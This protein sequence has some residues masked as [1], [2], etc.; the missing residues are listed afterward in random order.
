MK[1]IILILGIIS[2]CSA[3]FC[4]Q[5]EGEYIGN[6]LSEQITLARN[7]NFIQALRAIEV[8]SQLYDNRKILSTSSFNQQI[9]IPVNQLHWKDALQLIVGYHNLVL[10][11]QP[12]MYL[13]RDV[14]IVKEK[15]AEE[16]KLVITPNSQQVRISAIFFKADRSLSKEVGINWLTLIDGNIHVN[17]MLDKGNPLEFES[18]R[19]IVSALFEKVIQMGGSITGE[20]GIGITKAPYLDMEIPRPGLDLMSR[21]KGAFDPQGIL[22]PGKIFS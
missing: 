22:N 11:E 5:E 20:H 1:K 14:E 3:V 9:G 21:I 2:L 4:Q 17:V 15:D 16:K 12:G 13:I 19:K 6:S 18:A 7:I 8:L 10:E